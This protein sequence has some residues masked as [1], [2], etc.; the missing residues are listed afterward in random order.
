[1]LLPFLR[2]VVPLNDG[3]R[4][5]TMP[6]GKGRCAQDAPPH[7]FEIG[8]F[9]TIDQKSTTIEHIHN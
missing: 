4:R 2:H 1:M 6:V 8:G 9:K 3:N 7:T 5:L